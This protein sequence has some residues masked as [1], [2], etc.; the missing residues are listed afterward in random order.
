MLGPSPTC[1]YLQMQQS[2]SVWCFLLEIFRVI[3]LEGQKRE[4]PK[5]SFSQLARLA[6]CARPRQNPLPVL[7]RLDLSATM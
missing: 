1:I 2:P 7:E 3:L 5:T 6:R 4:A